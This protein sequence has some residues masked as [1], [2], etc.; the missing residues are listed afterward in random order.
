MLELNLLSEDLKVTIKIRHIYEA[1]IKIVI[2]LVI[3]FFA[4]MIFFI[5]AAKILDNA[6][7]EVL[8][9]ENDIKSRESYLANEAKEITNLLSA[10]IEVQSGYVKWSE[11]LAEFL[12]RDNQAIS[13][14]DFSVYADKKVFLLSGQA[15]NRADL[16]DF[17]KYLDDISYVKSVDLPMQNI[18]ERQA[19]NFHLA[20]N[21]DI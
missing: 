19:V 7:A 20:I 21:I 16:L 11:Y 6:Y 1:I 18:T 2:Y 14:S 5:A 9:H 15:R 17:K 3:A 8:I 10:V 13:I 4:I 12:A